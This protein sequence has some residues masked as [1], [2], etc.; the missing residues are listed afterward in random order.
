MGAVAGTELEARAAAAIATALGERAA[1]AGPGPPS[2]GDRRRTALARRPGLERPGRG[3][4]ADHRPAPGPRGALRPCLRRLAPGRRVPGRRR[5]RPVPLR[6]ASATTSACARC[7]KPRSRSATCSTPASPCPAA[8]SSSRTGSATRTAPPRIRRRCSMRSS[9]C[10]SPARGCRDEAASWPRSSTASPRP[11]RR[12]SWRGPLAAHGAGA[13]NDAAARRGARSSAETEEGVEARLESAR[14]PRRHRGRPGRS[15]NPAV[16]ESLAAVPAYGG[17]TLEGFDVCS[18]RWFV[19]HE[20]R[21][22]PLDPPPDPLVQGGIAHEVLQRLYQE[23]P[24]GGRSPG[25]ARWRLAPTGARAVAR[26]RAERRL[27]D[28]PG[29]RA[30]LR[31]VEGWIGRFLGEEAA[32]RHR[33]GSSP[34]CWR[35]PSPRTRT[36]SGRLS[37]S[38]AGGCTARSTASTAAPDG[39]ALVLDYKLSG[40]VTARKKLEE[41]A[42]LQLQL[43]LLA[44]AEL[45]QPEPV[46]GLYHPLRGTSERR[47]RGLVLEEVAD[48]ARLLRTSSTDEVDEAELAELLEDAAP[49]RRRDRRPDAR[50]G[51]RPRPGPAA[52]ACAATANARP[53]AS[54]RRSAGATGP[55]SSSRTRTTRRT[56][57]VSGRQPT[58]EQ[59][60]AIEAGRREVMVEAG[61]GT[62]KTGVMVDRYCRLVREEGVR[63]TRSSPSP[64]PTR[65]RPSCASGSGPRSIPERRAS[66]RR[67]WSRRSTA[68]ATGCS[69][70]TRSRSESTRASGSS[71]R[72]R[73]RGSRRGLRRGP[74]GVPRGGDRR[75]RGDARRLRRRR[76]AGD[77]RSPPTPSCAAAARPARRCRSRPP[78]DLAG[79][80]A[81]ARSR[82]PPSACRS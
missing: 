74:R 31:R 2:D 66:G 63:P 7:A 44:V 20:L 40:A 75:A 29:E 53:S 25:P 80:L 51:H 3:P 35:R 39:R 49:T 48:G 12:P 54:S 45:W 33:A 55:R 18:Y 47:P 13:D 56:A 36:P 57:P 60:A 58:E 52:P 38:T 61:A 42:K 68:S 4:G 8:A 67:T 65:P 50:R 43:Y 69:P 76:P 73:P 64:S 41:E 71:T 70:P 19:S 10:W 82:R 28:H 1:A 11:P 32:A 9:A 6:A 46:G 26:S 23:P 17:T 24:G 27:G 30:M 34:G 5:D 14:G 72:R 15:T 59:L 16:I 21:P 22:Q 79:A 77:R 62:G 81:A 78:A 37:R